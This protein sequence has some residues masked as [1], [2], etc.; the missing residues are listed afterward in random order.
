MASPLPAEPPLLHGAQP[1]STR[2]VLLEDFRMLPA[3]SEELVLHRFW[4]KYQAIA[5][6]T[7]MP[8]LSPG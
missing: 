6:R 7:T 2:S 5:T 4:K 1:V 8:E 3:E